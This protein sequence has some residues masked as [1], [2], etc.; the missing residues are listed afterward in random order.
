M[1]LSSIRQDIDG[2]LLGAEDFADGSDADALAQ[3]ALA[4]IKAE[5]CAS[6]IAYG[7][8]RCVG[9]AAADPSDDDSREAI[10]PA[11]L[12]Y[13]GVLAIDGIYVAAKRPCTP[14]PT[15]VPAI[16]RFDVDPTIREL[17]PT[18]A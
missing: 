16:G 15:L 17:K 18:M 7:A 14:A 5:S 12:K 2:D 10:G 6:R 3:D 1:R 11:G 13:V 9:S 8:P 4:S